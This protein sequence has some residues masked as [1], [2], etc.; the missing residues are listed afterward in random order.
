MPLIISHPNTNPAI[1]K[2]EDEI[3]AKKQKLA[4]LISEEKGTKIEDYTFQ[5]AEGEDVLLSDLFK[6]KE[7]LIMVFY[8]GIQCKY[9]SLWAD[10]YN[11]IVKPLN[12]RCSF[13][14]TSHESPLKQNKIKERR[15][16]N[17]DMVSRK[18][19]TFAHDLK[20]TNEDG[21]PLPGVASFIKKENGIYLHHC[22]YFGPGDNYCNMWDFTTI[23]SK[24]INNWAP[25]INY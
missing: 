13:V 8:M 23:L 25:K 7:E 16:W 24:G 14:V 15:E 6:N 9:C 17:F 5:N 11:G 20:F 2:I 1:R 21:N 12:D 4:Q 18:N 22:S 10:N 3:A 19:N